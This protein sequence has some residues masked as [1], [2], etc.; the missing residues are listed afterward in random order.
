M[1]CFFRNVFAAIP[2]ELAGSTGEK[3]GEKRA[4]KGNCGK[5]V[6]SSFLLVVGR[7]GD[8]GAQMAGQFGVRRA[9]HTCCG[10]WNSSVFAAGAGA[11]ERAAFSAV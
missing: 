1:V 10:T 4:G 2:E 6:R 3:N 8:V 7:S 5:V 11:A 9:V